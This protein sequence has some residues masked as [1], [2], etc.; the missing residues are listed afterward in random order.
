MDN[1]GNQQPQ[2][3]S[4]ETPT[5]LTGETDNLCPPAAGS[6]PQI[7]GLTEATDELRQKLYGQG[8][9]C[10]DDL[11]THIGRDSDTGLA[12]FS[13]D[14]QITQAELLDLLVKQAQLE[15]KNRQ[16][17]RHRRW[18]RNLKDHWLDIALGL[19]ALSVLFLF[20]RAAGLLGS[21]PY[22]LGLRSTVLVAARD[23]EA[24]R[25]LSDGDLT[26]ARLK[27]DYGYF[28][29]AGA[30][31]GLIL[32][33]GL[34]LG[35]PLRFEH[36]M[37]LQVVAARDLQLGTILA[38]QDFKYAWTPYRSDA[39]I[40]YGELINGRLNRALAA[41]EIIAPKYVDRQAAS[42]LR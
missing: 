25:V 42:T 21:L 18:W 2:D 26:G 35:E 13:T 19:A 31:R 38:S 6:V 23:L 39:V 4:N 7:I 37:R 33:N 11:W 40:D 32:T 9:K 27:P 12:G 14:A 20:L 3:K 1:A 16:G 5:Q 24:G 36:V 29:E 41:G 34:K 10:A 17:P 22:P 8:V 28:T 15:F 30:V